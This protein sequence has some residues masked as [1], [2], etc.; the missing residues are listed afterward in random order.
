MNV[1]ANNKNYIVAEN[2]DESSENEFPKVPRL[3]PENDSS[4][5]ST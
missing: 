5:R 3:D 1:N 4:Y 2:V